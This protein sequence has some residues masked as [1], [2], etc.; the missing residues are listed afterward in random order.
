M[1]NRIHKATNSDRSA[2]V[3]NGGRGSIYGIASRLLL[4]RPEV[5][6]SGLLALTI[7]SWSAVAEAQETNATLTETGANAY[8]IL[9]NNT[10]STTVGTFWYAW[11]PDLNYMAVLPT[12]VKSPSGWTDTITHGGS[13][14]GYGIEWTATAPANDLAAGA[15][16][17]GF[18]FDSTLDRGDLTTNNSRFYPNTPVG[19]S[20][21][22]THGPYSSAGDAFVVTPA[23]EP[24]T[25]VLAVAGTAA[26]LAARARIRLFTAAKAS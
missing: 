15:S 24:S 2:D 8:S 18:S 17:S 3:Q 12:N 7:A 26:L 23:P 21:T 16:L 1:R 14:D 4:G 5:I 6:L 25:L 19:T 9:L 11:Y 13:S 22:Y 10:G 20:V